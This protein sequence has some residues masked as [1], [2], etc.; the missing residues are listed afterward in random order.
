MPKT[1]PDY[2]APAWASCLYW[3]IGEPKIREAFS[4]QTGIKWTPARTAID[5]MVDQA[6]GADKKYMEAFVK[7]F[8]ECVW[9]D[10]NEAETQ[11]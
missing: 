11:G 10:V 3:A 8:N 2:M 7:W 9:G 4:E 6:T 1:T 5:R